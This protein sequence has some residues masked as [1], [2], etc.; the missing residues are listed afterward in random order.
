MVSKLAL[1]SLRA[2]LAKTSRECLDAVTKTVAR[3]LLM[4]V[5]AMLMGDLFNR[6][7]SNKLRQKRQLL[8]EHQ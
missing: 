2:P 5:A 7:P 4:L 8:K 3:Y 6:L 1:A